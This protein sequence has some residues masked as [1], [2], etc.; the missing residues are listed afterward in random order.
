MCTHLRHKLHS[1]ALWFV[2][3]ISTYIAFITFFALKDFFWIILVMFVLFV[4]D[5]IAFGMHPVF[6]FITFYCLIICLYFLLTNVTHVF[7]LV[8][9]GGRDRGQTG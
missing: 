3:T 5:F 1:I 9:G 2:A 6:A 7:F 8:R 4:C